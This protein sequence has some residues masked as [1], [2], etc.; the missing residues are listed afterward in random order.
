MSDLPGI[1]IVE[2]RSGVGQELFSSIDLRSGLRAHVVTTRA[3]S[4]AKSLPPTDWANPRTV[5]FAW[6]AASAV[7]RRS[8]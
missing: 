8:R 7:P 5:R 1:A 3:V 2:G 6:P 4:N